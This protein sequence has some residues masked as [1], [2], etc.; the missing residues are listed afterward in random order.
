VLTRIHHIGVAV[1]DAAAAL[2]FYSDLLGLPVTKDAVIAEQGVRGILLS[3]GETEIELLE[4]LQPDSA[5]GRF[6]AQR[7]EGLHHVC[8]ET[9]DIEQ[10]LALARSRGLPLVDDRPRPGLAGM[11]AFLH[12]KATRGVLVEYAQPPVSDP[13]ASRQIATATRFEHVAVAVDDIDAGVAVFRANFDLHERARRALPALAVRVAMLPI[14]ESWIGVA[15][16]LSADGAVARFLAE[17]GEGLYSICLDVPDLEATVRTLTGGGANVGEPDST[18]VR[19]AFV[20]PP[21]AGGAF[22]QLV[23]GGLA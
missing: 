18:G 19:V 15:A 16:P 13:N 20:S 8:F 1:R 3:A 5:V 4:P 2:R 17:R 10:E 14:G 11:I 7:G 23:A 6:L 22:I 12:P 21:S 9:N